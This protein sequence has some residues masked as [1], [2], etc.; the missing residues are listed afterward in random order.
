MCKIQD[1]L[2]PS[3]LTL[4]KYFMMSAGIWKLDLPTS[5]Y[6]YRRIYEIYSAFVRIYFPLLV[7]SLSIQFVISIGNDKSLDDIFKELS[8]IIILAIAE[9][10][11][12]LCQ[13]NAFKHIMSSIIDEE[14][15]IHESGDDDVLRY[16]SAQIKFC[17][18][19]G[20]TI[21]VFVMGTATSIGL[22]NIWKRLEVEKFNKEH[23]ESAAKPFIYEL[24]LYKLDPYKYPNFMLFVNYFVLYVNAFPIISTK[25]IFISCIVFTSSSLR[26]LQVGFRK[27]ATT[28]TRL[29]DLI[30][31]H[32]RVIRFV[33]KLNDSIRYMILMEYLLNSLDVA[34]VSIQFIAY[35]QGIPISPLTYF[36][37][38]FVQTFA[39][40]WSAN[41]IQ[42]QNSDFF[43]SQ[44]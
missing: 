15:R 9:V 36:L 16:H 3:I 30:R 26:R 20:L 27:T 4:P 1:V 22:E 5:N 18:A 17:N 28:S 25:I 37:Y 13:G 35:E 11:A 14:R 6:V 32:Q 21:I 23:N 29:V 44:I 33:E 31:Q 43:T 41:E 40:G 7:S 8:F 12:I 10:G 42:I 19:V 34:A 38:L 39:L 2:E 24:Y